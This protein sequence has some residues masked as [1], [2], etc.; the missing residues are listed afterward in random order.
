MCALLFACRLV[1]KDGNLF[2]ESAGRKNCMSQMKKV[3]LLVFCLCRMALTHAQQI[4]YAEPDRDD[5]R[6]LNFEIIGKMNDNF[7]IAKA[8][9]DN[10]YIATYDNTMKM[11][12]KHQLGF[13][14]PRVIDV[15]YL[16]YKDFFYLFYQYQH[17]SIVYSMGVKMDAAGKKVG[18]PILLDTTNVSSSS[19]KKIYTVLYSEDKQKIGILKINARNDKYHAVTLNLFDRDL[20]LLHKSRVVLPMEDR[21]DFLTEFVLDNDGDL[22]FLRAAGTSQ[23]DN[24]SRL[25]LILK[26]AMEDSVSVHEVD[27][28]KLYMDDMRLKADNVNKHYLITSFYSKTR[29]GNID[30]LYCSLWDKNAHQ[31]IYNKATVFS[32]DLRNDAKG[33]NNAK[34]A[35]NDFFLQNIV[36][37]KDGGYVIAA[38][39]VYTS[40]RS[41]PYNRWDYM[42]GSPFFN[43]YNSYYYYY[44]PYSFYYPWWRWN[45]FSNQLVRYFADNIAVLS[46][47][48]TGS[49][50]WSNVI[51]KSQYD[52]NTDNFLGYATMTSGNE[53]HFIFNQLE[54]RD[55]L[56]NDQSITAEGQLHRNPTF[57][58]LDKGYDFMPRFAKQVSSWQL[59]VP[60]VYR[61]YISFAKIEF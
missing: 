12:E 2:P 1:Q 4:V 40:S 35:F 34:T 10:Y 6:N 42:Y 7:L 24:I 38:E 36:M 21:R 60:C 43:P 56:L 37:R 15:S 30:G 47:D 46:F 39:S 59:I 44:S 18:E 9:R 54:K 50:E 48:T 45:S 25:D 8:Y 27:L 19:N 16:A 53:V 33:D 22:A 11:V 5:A 13:L 14:P 49:I 31:L 51:R 41:G 29:R 17:K 52:D 32:D 3:L 55:W 20:A 26:K 23:N 58:N 57:K 61:N 28:M